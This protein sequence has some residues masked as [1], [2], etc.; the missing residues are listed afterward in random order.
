MNTSS[1]LPADHAAPT[2]RATRRRRRRLYVATAA[3]VVAV[4]AV[5]AVIVAG[6]REDSRSGAFTTV[7]PSISG[8]KIVP[9]FL[10]GA[11]VPYFE[12][13][14]YAGGLPTGDYT[15]D[16]ELAV[17]SGCI[18]FGTQRRTH[19]VVESTWNVVKLNYPN[20]F[21]NVCEGSEYKVRVRVGNT[22]VGWTAFSDFAYR[23]AAASSGW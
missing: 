18:G 16:V 9:E 4:I 6:D 5:G 20:V 7:K 17:V 2:E 14:V 11:V 21:S 3:L 19:P 10:W 12:F 22:Q 23:K 8:L 15:Y 13:T 1:E